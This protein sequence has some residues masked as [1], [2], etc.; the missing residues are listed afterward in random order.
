MAAAKAAPRKWNAALK[1]KTF[2]T[3]YVY[4]LGAL[5]G[6]YCLI[7][8]YHFTVGP[9][10]VTVDSASR[11]LLSSGGEIIPGFNGNCPD[12]AAWEKDSLAIIH[13]I[14]VT[15]LFLG[16]AIICDEQF[17]SSLESICDPRTGLGLSPDVAGA[18]FMAAGSS[19]P[20]LASSCMG[21][22]VSKVRPVT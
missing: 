3:G 16:I 20:E 1:S 22:F 11:K 5:V 9:A 2:R 15:Y 6:L 21:T 18:T 4:F 10:E 19:A 7:Q 8:G 12:Q 13:V 14:G 17:T